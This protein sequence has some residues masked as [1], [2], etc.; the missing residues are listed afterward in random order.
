M[1]PYTD[2]VLVAAWLALAGNGPGAEPGGV[3]GKAGTQFKPSW[4]SLKA[5]Q[6]PNWFRDAKFG[7][8]AHWGPQCVPEQGDWYAQH[9]YQEG[10]PDY[11]YHLA[12]YGHPSKFGFKDICQS[13][14]AEKWDPEKLMDLYQRAGA[15]YFVAMANHHDNFDNWNSKYQPWNSVNFGPKQDIVGTWSKL[16]RQ[17]NL[18]F[19]VTVHA[20]RAWSWYSVAHGADQAGPMKGIPYDGALTKANGQ[21]LWWEGYDPADLYG[22]HGA[23]RTEAAFRAYGR[24]FYNRVI[25]LVDSYQPDLLYFDDG[26]LPGG[27]SGLALAAYYYNANQRWHDGKLEAVLTIKNPPSGCRGAVLLD[28]EGGSM[29]HLQAFPWQDDTCIGEWHY[30][31][32]IN[33][34]SVCDVLQTLVDVV[35]KNGNMLL[36][37]PIRGDGSIDEKETKL[38]EDLAAW[39]KVNEAAIFGT[40]PWLACGENKPNPAYEEPRS[41]QDIR[42]TIKGHKLYALA[43]GWPANQKLTVRSLASTK[44]NSVG[45][46]HD[47]KLLGHSGRLEW[48]RSEHGLVVNLPRQK[49]CEH[50][51]ALE[52]TGQD[53]KPVPVDVFVTPDADG[54]I[55]LLGKRIKNHGD[56]QRFDCWKEFAYWENPANYI[57]WDLRIE[58]PGRYDLKITYGCAPEC[59]GRQCTYEIAGQTLKFAAKGTG[60][61][62]DLTTEKLG[63]VSFGQAGLHTLTVKSKESRP[64]AI[65]SITLALGE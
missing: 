3:P 20:A 57:S 2:V 26:D 59:Q 58:K 4:E 47:V 44:D 22:E 30:R 9:M 14:K 15:K 18:R 52:I 5:Y 40:R 38:L 37:I 11:K 31:R 24:K 10:H 7:I 46:I 8:W 32:N 42:F 65:K 43:L 49:P 1:R 17:H 6:Y 27:N 23:A 12:A 29:D 62:W 56:I 64:I 16:A 41:S 63:S 53:L 39:M 13:W 36:N 50:V 51:F 21:G 55:V 61:W 25:D 19:G 33:Y 48:A 34:R 45:T 28:V 54:R 35:S 60:S